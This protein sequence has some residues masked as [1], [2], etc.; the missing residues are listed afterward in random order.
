MMKHHLLSQKLLKTVLTVLMCLS[1]TLGL[2]QLSHTAPQ[3][4]KSTFALAENASISGHAFATA[5]S[6]TANLADFKSDCSDHL[7]MDESNCADECCDGICQPFIMVPI[8]APAKP[9]LKKTA[10]LTTDGFMNRSIAP[11]PFPP[12]K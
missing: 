12:R 3:F 8:Y 1:F 4:D 6:R 7:L 11:L 9:Q 10:S 5:H 2:T